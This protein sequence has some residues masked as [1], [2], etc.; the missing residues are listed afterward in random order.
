LLAAG[1]AA[2]LLAAWMGREADRQRRELE[3]ALRAQARLL[4]GA[5]AP[6]LGEAAAAA[7]E[8][9]ELLAS[10][11][12]GEARSLARLEAA[13]ALPGAEAALATSGL[14]AAV[15]LSRHGAPLWR[16]GEAAA[17]E[18]EARAAALLAAAGDELVLA[19]EA[20]AGA[21]AA[22]RTRDGGVL[23]V[24]ARAPSALARLGRP[25]IER[26]L[27]DLVGEG[28]VLY[29][30]Y[31]EPPGLEGRAAWDGGPV[32]ATPPP[33]GALRGRPVFEVQVPVAAP[34]GRR[35]TLRVGL[36]AASPAGAPGA[37]VRRTALVGG[38]L[39]ALGLLAT[40]YAEVQRARWREREENRRRLARLEE[41][42]RRSERLAAAGALAAGLAHEVRNP[43][44]AIGLAAQRLARLAGAGE[45]GRVLA[46]R[47]RAEVGRL[48]TTLKDFLDLG[49]PAGAERE[50]HDL[51]D[52]ARDVV[53][54]LE[55][56]AAERHV[57]LV[58]QLE[59][60]AARVDREAVR[61]ALVNLMRNALEASPA[62]AQ[63][64][65]A[66][67]TLKSARTSGRLWARLAV[68]D[69]GSGIDPEFA[70]RAFDAFVTTKAGGSGLGLALVRRV[71][72]EHG[73]RASLRNHP[74]G[75][76]EALLEL[77]L[78]KER[79]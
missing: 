60:V 7:R 68:R 41:E 76:V 75:G 22:V 55:L 11:L 27:R 10:K 33:D 71:A 8:L 46:A 16:W 40:A 47:I 34:G 63:V 5:L 18:L 54:L 12:L 77:P 23:A 66:V 37:A 72:E 29:L 44:N 4:A 3:S 58:A 42:R 35:A 26:L 74:A 49:R 69:S 24:A 56:E 50:L 61:R 14:D 17:L 70:E 62:G 73:G 59:P 15:R 52:L 9:E 31:D 28:A 19:S 64:E 53:A 36:D 1:C 30:A 48:E 51:A 57:R 78:E 25:G 38:A 39:A 43:L 13:G 32:P 65:V 20:S 45:E 2:A 67:G 6:A 79:A 21:G